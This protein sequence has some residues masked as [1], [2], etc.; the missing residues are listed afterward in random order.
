MHGQEVYEEHDPVVRKVIEPYLKRLELL[1]RKLEE[2]YHQLD[3]RVLDLRSPVKYRTALLVN[4]YHLDRVAVL[5]EVLATPAHEHFLQ[6]AQEV[7]LLSQRVVS[8]H[9]VEYAKKLDLCDAFQYTL[10]L[11]DI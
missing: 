7:E 9:V 2:L 11:T 1:W 4:R 10:Y 5:D 6:V 3:N 8:G